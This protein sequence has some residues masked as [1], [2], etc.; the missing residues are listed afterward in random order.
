MAVATDYIYH[1]EYLEA[2]DAWL[3]FAEDREGTFWFPVGPSC[4]A[5]GIDAH[6]QVV[7]IQ[8]DSRLAPWLREI[9]LPFGTDARG[10]WNNFQKTH[11]LRRREYSWWL[12]MID[13]NNVKSS[14]RPRLESRQRALMDLSDR[15]MFH[16]HE[17]EIAAATAAAPPSSPTGGK[18]QEHVLTGEF[19]LRCLRCGAPHCVT[20]DGTRVRV[21]LGQDAD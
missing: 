19:H 13:P 11:V 18:R 2:C 3:T 21:Y 16:Q 10:Q 1:R 15:V 4:R 8:A 20:L 12:A 14:S 17:Q 5:M 9:R 6:S 7:V